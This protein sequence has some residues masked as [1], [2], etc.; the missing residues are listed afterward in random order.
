MQSKHKGRILPNGLIKD[1]TV[2]NLAQKY[3]EKA[4]R[5]LEMM[6]I[7]SQLST[8]KDAQK[9][10]KLPEYYSNDE[11]IIITSY[12]SM[13]SSALALLAKIGYKSDVHT[14]TIWAIKKFFVEKEIIG[15]EYLAML[16]NLKS[17]IGKHDVDALS[18]G[19]E[20][21]EI[22]QYNVTKEITH[23]IAEESIKNAYAFVNKS[24]EIIQVQN[25]K[26]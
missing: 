7:I 19:K 5:N 3:L 22:A 2:K 17:H 11:W 15:E 23:S 16:N 9:A 12:Y 6:N 10:L 26:S 21:R 24:R 1:E 4:Y 25:N 13:Y 18:K 8:N 20:N 14:S